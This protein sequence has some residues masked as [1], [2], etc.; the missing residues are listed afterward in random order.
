MPS[1]II[2]DESGFL[3]DLK[4]Q[5]Q[6]A[7]KFSNPK[8]EEHTLK[9]FPKESYEILNQDLNITEL[10]LSQENKINLTQG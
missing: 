8:K 4:I 3:I 10:S 7:V 6:I 1:V 2:F 5:K 9:S